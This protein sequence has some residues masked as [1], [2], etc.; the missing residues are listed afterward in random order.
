MPGRSPPGPP[1]GFYW[2]A[3]CVFFFSYLI[4][5][6]YKHYVS[7][8]ISY[9]V[10]VAFATYLFFITL[11]LDNALC[12]P[13]VYSV[14]SVNHYPG[15]L[16]LTALVYFHEIY[17]LLLWGFYPESS[18]EGTSLEILIFLMQILYTCAY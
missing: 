12:G 13:A 8:R 1:R 7:R 4:L 9:L 14:P 17:L 3:D 6:F 10:F 18:L 5:F 2:S 16:V 15:D 11:I